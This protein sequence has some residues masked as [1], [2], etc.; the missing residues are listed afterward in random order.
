MVVSKV[1]VQEKSGNQYIYAYIP[2]E[3]AK[4][5]GIGKNNP[6]L[7][8]KESENNIVICSSFSIEE[9]RRIVVKEL[10]EEKITKE[11][12]LQHYSDEWTEEL[13]EAVRERDN[14][15]CQKCHRIEEPEVAFDVH[16]INEDKENPYAELITLCPYCHKITRTGNREEHRKNLLEI[17]NSRNLIGWTKKYL[18]NKYGS[19]F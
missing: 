18:E 14:Y 4:Y 12:Y 5:I 9:A 1:I 19:T 11:K 6:Y 8:W 2:T 7:E 13:R 10:S 3:I 16:H 17:L 15:E